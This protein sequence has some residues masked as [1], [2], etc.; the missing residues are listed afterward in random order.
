MQFIPHLTRAGHQVTCAPLFDDH[1]IRA[2]YGGLWLQKVI[3]TL[4]AY[5][6]RV[7]HL[8]AVRQYDLVWFEKELFPYMPPVA[9]RY[10]RWLGMATVVDFDDAVYVGYHKIPVLR[11]KYHSVLRTA[12][13]II[14]GNAN[15]SAWALQAGGRNI[16]IV[17][18]VVDIQKYASSQDEDLRAPIVI[19]W[20]GTPKTSHF[21]RAVES[22]LIF[23]HERYGCVIRVIGDP[24]YSIPTIGRV[25]VEWSE[26]TEAM[27][28]AA[29]DIGIMPL[30][31]DEFSRGKC[32]YKLIQYMASSK[33]V[34]ASPVGVNS[35]IVIHGETGLL[36][37][38]VEEWK[39]ALV[40]LCESATLRTKYGRSGQARALEYYSIDAVLPSIVKI[41]ESSCAN[42][43]ST[44]IN[45]IEV[46]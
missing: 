16:H 26:T 38:S 10:L 22:A 46:T 4:R 13:A 15:L 19:G 23:A 35:Q 21:L 43:R 5:I 9:E 18:T 29:I 31:D 40:T 37:S 42:K 30:T 28:L 25:G 33:P 27:M 6:A 24:A 11:Y 20:I 39:C 36:A 8:L 7:M 34:I 12:T 44:R 17:P 1:Y 41:L 32:G 14:V 3:C 45:N 2:L